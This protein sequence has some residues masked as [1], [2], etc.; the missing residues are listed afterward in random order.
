M[1]EPIDADAA[2]RGEFC[3]D[4]LPGCFCRI[5]WPIER[6]CPECRNLRQVGTSD[7]FS[8]CICPP[9]PDKTERGRD[10]PGDGIE[11][12]VPGHWKPI[13]PDD[14]IRRG[15]NGEMVI[16]RR[17]KLEPK[18]AFLRPFP[19]YID[20]LLYLW[21]LR[22]LETPWFA[23]WLHA[24]HRPDNQRED[25][26]DHPRAFASFVLRGKYIEVF[27]QSYPSQ[28]CWRVVRWL[29]VKRATDAHQIVK[30]SRSPVWTL[31]FCGPRWRRW[32]FV[33]KDGWVDADAYIA[34]KES[35]K[36]PRT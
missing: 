30:L 32:G 27:P 6:T 13:D 17:V 8:F 14:E 18:W 9:P 11:L 25:L 33:T 3:K 7:A 22:I 23:I 31:V 34:A 35:A 28:F 15:A 21:R 1:N 5:G 36:C 10:V 16:V 19:I 2:R 26:H 24:I 20:G 4:G 29:N 12:V